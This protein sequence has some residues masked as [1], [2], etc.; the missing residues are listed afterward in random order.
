MAYEKYGSSI[1]IGCGP[2]QFSGLSNDSNF[3]YL[4]KN[5]SYFLKD[6]LGNTLPYLDSVTFRINTLQKDPT[7]FFLEKD[8]MIL[9]DLPEDKVEELFANHHEKFEN[10][11]FILD[12]KSV[13]GTDCYELNTSKPPFEISCDDKINFS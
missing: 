1:T 12:R 11:E 9:Y 3:I 4:T 2:F 5:N 10:K 13:L 8:I 7:N 6:R